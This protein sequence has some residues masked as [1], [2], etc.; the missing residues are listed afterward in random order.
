MSWAEIVWKTVSAVEKLQSG[1]P[2]SLMGPKE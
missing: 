1:N 2:F